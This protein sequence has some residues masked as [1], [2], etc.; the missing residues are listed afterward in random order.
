MS[1]RG[2]WV[3]LSCRWCDRPVTLAASNGIWHKPA[4]RESWCEHFA[5]RE[6]RT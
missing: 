2:W 4:D 6:E 3:N 1:A 5:C